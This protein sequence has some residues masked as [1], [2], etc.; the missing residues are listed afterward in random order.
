MI[1][2]WLL[3]LNASRPEEPREVGRLRVVVDREQEGVAGEARGAPRPQ[4]Y[5]EADPAQLLD[6]GVGVHDRRRYPV[7]V[8]RRKGS[9]HGLR[10]R[11]LNAN[12]PAS[13]PSHFAHWAWVTP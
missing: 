9:L 2:P 8:A 10:E 1:A 7:G 13:E 5:A 11:A 12:D 4:P 3:P 6:G